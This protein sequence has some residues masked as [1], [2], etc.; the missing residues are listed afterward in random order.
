MIYLDHHAASPIS[1][2]VREAM[3]Q[4]EDT[5]WANPSSVH[6]AGR[7]SKALV[8]NAR[9]V[10][11][12]AMGASSPA[13]VTFVSGGTEA[14]ALAILGASRP[15][16]VVTTDVEHPSVKESVDRLG[17]PVIR[18]PVPKG[19]PPSADILRAHLDAESLVVISYVNHETGT[20]FP[21]EAYGRVCQAANARLIVDA[22]QAWGKVDFGVETLGA[23]AV[24]FASHKIGGP[25][26]AGALW[27]RRGFAVHPVLAG[28]GQ[29]RGRR[30]G[31]QNV[32][33]AVGFAAA[34]K[35]LPDRLGKVGAM[36]RR[37]E[38]IVSFLE[39]LG[40]RINA[41]DGPRVG[42]VAS[43]AFPNRRSDVLVAALDVEGVCV[44]SG[45]ACSSGVT[46]ASPVL[47]AMHADEPWRA[48][49]TLRISLGPETSDQDVEVACRAFKRVL[50]R[51]P[52]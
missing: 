29:E 7:A 35:L 1:E 2:G 51:L 3:R 25:G 40:G 48:S 12:N 43:L 45:A 28:G 39:T 42:S 11:A 16:R 36:T 5:A 19:A 10:L 38:E 20:V 9:D 27:T 26:G 37:R 17:V 34:A 22:T 18:L 4:A 8:E 30:P 23:D 32:L 13:D 33:A 47:R 15:A 31:T 14:V 52:V 44:S 24:A 50:T 46:T 49:S 41:S 6:A 21:V